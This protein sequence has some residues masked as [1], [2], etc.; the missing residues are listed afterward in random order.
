[1]PDHGR[2]RGSSD[3]ILER[4]IGLHPKLIDLSLDRIAELLA[5]LGSPERALAPVIHVAGTNG[6]GSTIAFMRAILEAA[7][8][9]VQAYI[10]PH[11]VRFHERIRL[12]GGL[13]DE[14]GLC[15]LLE[16]CEAANQGE[17]ITYFEITTAAAFL[18][19]SRQP[20][21]A[22]LLEVG[23]GGRFDAT[24]IVAAPKVCVIT[25]VS[26][27][28]QQFLG[29]GL[30]AIA[31]E[32]AGIIKPGVPVVV[33][34][35]D[36]SVLTVIKDKARQVGA[37]VFAEG[38]DWRVQPAE[39]GRFR[40]RDSR[41]ELELASPSLRGAHQMWNAGLAIAALRH[42]PSC[43]PDPKA[44]A[45]GLGTAAWPGRLQRLE[46]G[47]LPSLLPEGSE[48]WLDGG[49]NPAAAEILCAYFRD[50]K[51]LHLIVG[52]MASKSVNDFL[53]P[54]QPLVVTLH[55]V[56]IPGEKG[57]IPPSDL[58]AI[59]SHQGISARSSDGVESALA[60]IAANCNACAPPTVVI[61]GSLYLA[62]T[63]LRLQGA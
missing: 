1:M 6:K 14:A 9:A 28:H 51:P 44:I 35:Q 45:A 55:A 8:K 22:L 2:R 41:G 37:P 13:I 25:P 36:P 52:M 24:N 50:K 27:D 42:F 3:R 53:A 57:C 18:A 56:A 11:L 15:A 46:E 32:K 40:Y 5:R 43:E 60:E 33:G 31:G 58:V 54:F 12:T 61:C 62:G 39:G 17:A 30:A 4:L 10:S 59:A 63:V 7:G 21:D 48:L 19:F 23:L 20:A 26:A 16:E 49:H 29:H 34:P 47:P 38:E